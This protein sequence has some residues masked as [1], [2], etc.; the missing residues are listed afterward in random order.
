[1][2][3]I[4]SVASAVE[5]YAN[6]NVNQAK[7]SDKTT[8]KTNVKPSGK[9]IGNPKLSEEAAKYY[10]KLKAKFS[11]MDFI[12][13]SN[14]QK[15]KAKAQAASYAN[16]NKMVVLID[17]EKIEKM[18]TDE[19]FR[20]QYEGII[21]NA[22]SG[23]SQLASKLSST[24]ANVKGYGMQV[25]D[26]GVATYFAVL[27]KSTVAQKERIEKKAIEKKEAAKEAK[28]KAKRKERE[29]R[30]NPSNKDKSKI[31]D[32]DDSITITASSID[33]LLRKIKDASMEFL[34][35]NTQSA[36]EKQIGQKFD[37]SI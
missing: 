15:E 25:G 17:E 31:K 9:T 35:D 13:V 7:N 36:V 16:A 22:A 5:M 28:I 30:L 11:N 37:F 21:A 8:G 14:D 29:E 26:N 33:E 20:K 27:E 2:S 10:D 6:Q 4:S 23:M 19:N 1:M 3:S 32:S 34:S 12:L 24:G 18:A